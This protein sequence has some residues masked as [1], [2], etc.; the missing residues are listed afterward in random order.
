MCFGCPITIYS[1]HTLIIQ[2]TFEKIDVVRQVHKQGMYCSLGRKFQL[3][4]QTISLIGL[5]VGVERDSVNVNKA[6]QDE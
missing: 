4:V 1:I 6:R 3:R 2:K 5:W